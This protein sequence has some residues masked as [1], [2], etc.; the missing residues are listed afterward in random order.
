MAGRARLG[1]PKCLRHASRCACVECECECPSGAP[2]PC[3]ALTIAPSAVSPPLLPPTS[4]TA[5]APHC[6][7][8]LQPRLL[9][10][11]TRLLRASR[12]S[13]LLRSRPHIAS[14]ASTAVPTPHRV[15]TGM[16]CPFLSGRMSAAD[17]AALAMPAGH[18]PMPDATDA[19]VAPSAPPLRTFTLASLAQAS[20]AAA[21]V[22]SAPRLVAV[23]GSVFGIP[24]TAEPRFDS[25][26]AWASAI[27]RDL[28]R[29]LAFTPV[30]SEAASAVADGRLRLEP[31][32]QGSG[33]LAGLDFDALRRLESWYAF[34]C[35]RHPVVGRLLA[36]HET[37]GGPA[38]AKCLPGEKGLQPLP[39]DVYGS[40]LPLQGA[41]GAAHALHALLDAD[42]REATRCMVLSTATDSPALHSRCSRTDMT[43]VHKVVEKGWGDVL[44][45][46]LA[47]RADAA[48]PCSLYDGEDALALARR[49]QFA[50]GVAALQAH[51]RFTGDDPRMGELI[52]PL[53]LQAFLDRAAAARAAGAAASRS[54]VAVLGFPHD[55]GCRRN[56]GRPGARDGPAV[57]RGFMS[58]MGTV[59]NPEFT[60]DLSTLDHVDIGDVGAGMA[61]DQLEH[62]HQLLR[63]HV[64]ALLRSGPHVIPFVVGG[65][66]DQSFPNACGL[67]DAVGPSIGVVNIDAHLDVRPLK[68]GKVHSGSPFRC[69]LEETRFAQ[70]VRGDGAAVMPAPS[71]ADSSASSARAAASS[72][73]VI[74]SMPSRRLQFIE[75]AAQGNQ[76]S[77]AH[78]EFVT[79]QH[80]QTIHWLTALR[81]RIAAEG[82][83]QAG[84]RTWEQGMGRQFSATLD[85]LQADH[86]FVSFDLDSV[87]G[88]DAPGVSCPGT[89]GLTA[90]EALDMCYVAGR[91]PKVR[92]FDL[93][94]FNPLID[95]YR[96]GRLVTNMWYWFC[97][98][99]ASRHADAASSAAVAPVAV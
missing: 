56:G 6:G 4:V 31:E 25:G 44:R 97:M 13:S 9:L 50:E 22:P 2:T 21:A 93:S 67:M 83:P 71:G 48:A 53:T 78:A 46:L 20:A 95:S 47:K 81:Q 69:L 65:S 57:V 45:V 37:A 35:E 8:A 15:R 3:T 90:A 94:E 39:G 74:A 36:E 58:K 62:A 33:A 32:H 89:V 51:R 19:P 82:A 26:G 73:N 28:T 76:C 16:A 87:S 5:A 27:G 86:L 12:R 52:Q 96:T 49:F 1:T 92:L 43:P 98:G 59:L 60:A 34:F 77:Q 14:F 10:P 85:S 91:C 40:F 68:Q 70:S 79:L 75:F 23:K 61:G 24:P 88:A 80:G 18:P 38:D 41:G 66:N 84:A 54:T 63:E 29:T 72:P 30:G 64:A 55:E 42:E 7:T 11:L 99:V 17:L